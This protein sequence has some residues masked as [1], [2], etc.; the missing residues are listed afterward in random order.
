LPKTTPSDAGWLQ[1]EWPFLCACASPQPDRERIQA[2]LAEGLDWEALLALAEEHS[3]EGVLMRRLAEAS[4]AGVP[5][6]SRERLRAS[7]RSRQLFSLSLSAELFHI[8]EEFS[9]A[10]V[11]SV[12]VKGPVVSLRAY[13]D[14][15]VRSFD[16]LDLLVRQRDI[17]KAAQNMVAM[18]FESKVHFSAMQ[19]GMIPGEYVFRRP[20]TPRI[21]ELHTEQTFRHYP[22]P[23]RIEELFKRKTQV[24][25]DGR[26][27]PALCLEDE[28]VLNCIHGAKDFWVRL[29]WVS[30]VAAMV[31]NHPELDWERTRRAAADVGAERML[32]VGV[33][34]GASLLGA[35]VADE[36]AAE[37]EQDATSKELCDE[38]SRWLPYGIDGLPGLR[39]RAIYRMRMAGGG[40]SGPIY[41]LRLSLS[42]T[43]EDWEKETE[44]RRSWLWGTLRRP[45]RLMRKYGSGE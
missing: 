28:L 16:D 13:G 35:K 33:R 2:L 8:L 29:M 39:K 26:K 32:H 19:T 5:A 11:E 40:I 22:R 12:P 15:A 3:V 24:H 6:D 43:E 37:I 21:V 20:G 31:T 25:L 36:M 23:M 41:L 27:V 1:K 10:D 7:M 38:V 34:L 4:Y 14:A 30:D 17:S 42:P 44:E 18:G 9:R 45:F